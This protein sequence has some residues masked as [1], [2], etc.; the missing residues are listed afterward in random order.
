MAQTKE[1]YLKACERME[2]II[3]SNQVNNNTPK[4]DPMLQ[5]L[6]EVSDIVMAYEE[7]HCPIG[8]PTLE[9]REYK[10]TVRWGSDFKG[11]YGQTL[12][13]EPDL[14]CYEG[15]TLKNLEKDFQSAMDL[16]LESK[17]ELTH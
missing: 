12:N 4:D 16:Y 15:D 11:Y 1:Q 14:V 7:E 3:K 13:I 2:E 5:E 6:D 17:D 9:Y 8:E 10:G